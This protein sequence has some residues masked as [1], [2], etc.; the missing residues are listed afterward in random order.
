MIEQECTEVR[1]LNFEFQLYISPYHLACYSRD[2]ISLPDFQKPIRVDYTRQPRPR[3]LL[4]APPP[5]PRILPL[6]IT[7]VELRFMPLR[8][9]PTSA[10]EVRT[11]V[12]VC[13]Y[14]GA[15]YAKIS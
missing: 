10:V 4:P 9:A 6:R 2:R 14:S 13:Q 1:F 5:P 15:L 12:E 11:A 3:S 8:P 7:A